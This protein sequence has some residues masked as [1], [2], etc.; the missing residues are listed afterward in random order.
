MK[1]SPISVDKVVDNQAE[2]AVRGKQSD[3]VV[4]AWQKVGKEV[5]EK[6]TKC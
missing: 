4:V 3:C 1:L 2:R 5:S 6:Q